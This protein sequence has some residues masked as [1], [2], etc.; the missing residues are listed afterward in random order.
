VWQNAVL[1]GGM[2]LF[3]DWRQGYTQ[4]GQGD[5]YSQRGL[6]KGNPIT[7]E[8]EWGTHMTLFWVD[9]ATQIQAGVFVQAPCRNNGK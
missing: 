8:H 6:R 5:G 4:K 2:P 1:A 9:L 3:F 7:Q